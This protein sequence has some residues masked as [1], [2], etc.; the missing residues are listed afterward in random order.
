MKATKINPMDH[1]QL[2][3]NVCKQFKYL[4]HDKRLP[5]FEYGDLFSMGF[6]GLMKACHGFDASKGF[7]FSTY[8]VPFIWG[9]IQRYIRD[10]QPAGVRVPRS[11]LTTAKVK[12]VSL[13]KKVSIEYGE[14]LE[15]GDLLGFEMNMDDK[16]H[17]DL[18]MSTLNERDLAILQLSLDGHGQGY[19]SEQVDVVQPQVSRL[20][21]KIRHRFVEYNQEAG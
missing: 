13:N 4:L 8:A 2:V 1:E 9:M 21:G 18:F 20:L 7:A 15:L 3:H 17:M 11:I 12:V 5:G 6:E 10:F 19:I 14:D 16:L